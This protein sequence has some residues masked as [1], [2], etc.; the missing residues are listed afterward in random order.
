MAMSR[1]ALDALQASRRRSARLAAALAMIAV[2]WGVLWHVVSFWNPAAFAL[3]WTGAALM[4]WHASRA[5]YPGLW[6]HLALAVTS[7]PLWWWF[8]FVNERIQNWHYISPFEVGFTA[9][10]G[11]S[12]V[13]SWHDL[14]PAYPS[15]FW[16]AFLSSLAFST[17]VPAVIAA[18]TLVR[19]L[20]LHQGV[21]A[22]APT[23]LGWLQII[24]GI[25]L[26]I[27]VFA[28][29]DQMYPFVWIAPFLL[30]DGLGALL[31]GHCL[32][33]DMLRRRWRETCLI[34]AAG[35]ICGLAWE[36]WN[37]WS[38]PSWEYRV[39]LLGFWK[40]FEMPLLG[41]AGYIPFAWSIV[42]L[43]RVLDL[44]WLRRPGRSRL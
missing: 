35:L 17:V 28:F 5:G 10:E 38:V 39:P 9:I 8:E 36:F 26:Q 20:S 37:Y 24:L 12:R 29:P 6:R 22:E 33:A 2:G 43:I 16:Y 14:S 21:L 11:F 40:V 23:R 13:Q 34:A 25:T 32:G 19:G 30:V 44:L 7:V 4:M 1:K 41:Y 31:D 27:T 42:F 3:L 18:T 15:I